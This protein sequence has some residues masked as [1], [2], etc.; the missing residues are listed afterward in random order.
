MA[1]VFEAIGGVLLALPD[2]LAPDQRSG[3]ENSLLLAWL[4][5]AKAGPGQPGT[6]TDTLGKIGWTLSALS[7]KQQSLALSQSGAAALDAAFAGAADALASRLAA[8]APD[9]VIAAW[10]GQAGAGRWLALA[11]DGEQAALTLCRFDIT[12][13]DERV[14]IFAADPPVQVT[15]AASTG[16]LNPAV[17]AQ[18][19]TT[20]AAKVQ[21]YLADIV[22]G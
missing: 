18:V 1:L 17:F 5:A 15:I 10:W 12:L 6:L 20:V 13:P 9:P 7:S 11:G 22:R 2:T 4:A 3:I 14:L 8:A 21:P 16:T 19:E